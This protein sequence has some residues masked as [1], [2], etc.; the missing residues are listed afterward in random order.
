MSF[1][2]LLIKDSAEE[3]EGTGTITKTYLCKADILEFARFNQDN[4]VVNIWDEL[5]QNNVGYGYVCTDIQIGDDIQFL[6]YNGETVQVCTVTATY[7]VD[8]DRYSSLNVAGW[9]L[10]YSSGGYQ[11]YKINTGAEW[12]DGLPLVGTENFEYKLPVTNLQMTTKIF[13]SSF[14][15]SKYSAATGCVNNAEWR[16]KE[17]GC[18]MLDG[19]SCNLHYTNKTNAATAGH[20]LQ[21]YELNLNFKILPIS[22]NLQWRNMVQKISEE[23][24][25]PVF[26]QSKFSDSPDYTT[27]TDLVGTPVWDENYT[28]GFYE[29]TYSDGT[30]LYPEYDFDSLFTDEE[31]E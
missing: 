25:Q 22:W 31:E 19:Y 13:A 12:S 7:T 1:S 21:W 6:H 9:T 3:T 10:N 24:R 27:N 23:D 16:G 20:T 11:A 2:Y 15:D 14:D 30:L 8:Y 28:P 4:G 17:A 18:V 29:V 26:W 5:K